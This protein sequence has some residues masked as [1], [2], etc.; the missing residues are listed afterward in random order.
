MRT[1]FGVGTP[2][3]LQGRAAA[4]FATLWWLLWHPVMACSLIGGR[5]ESQTTL[6]DLHKAPHVRG[7][8][9]TVERALP[10]AARAHPPSCASVG[11]TAV[12][13]CPHVRRRFASEA[14]RADGMGAS[15]VSATIDS[16]A[17]A[18]S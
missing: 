9:G 13:S 4:L 1:L 6:I 10:R 18:R 11:A 16:Y 2:R 14:V 15:V 3:G 17:T 7:I 12:W 5:N 8:T